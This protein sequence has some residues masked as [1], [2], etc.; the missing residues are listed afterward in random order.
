KIFRIAGL[1]LNQLLTAGLA[2]IGI[3]SASFVGFLV[4]SNEFTNRVTF[5]GI[6]IEKILPT[7][8]HHPE[9]SSPI[10]EMVITDDIVPKVRCDSCQGVSQDR[11][12]DVAHVHWLRDIRRPEID[13]DAVRL[14]CPRNTKSLILQELGDSRGNNFRSENEIDEP[15]ACAFRQLAQF[16][17]IKV[18]DD[19]VRQ[20]ARIFSTLF[21]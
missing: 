19:G 1:Q 16:G 10:A 5:Q 14:C 9:L 6:P 4:D 20:G 7:V 11:T 8:N 17:Y 3:S 18:L 2:H 15:G 21:G 13:D 12:A